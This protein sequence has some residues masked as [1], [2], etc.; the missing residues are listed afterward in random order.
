MKLASLKSHRDGTLIVVDSKLQRYVVAEGI[1]VTLQSALDRWDE[2]QPQ[3]LELAEH[4]EQG[5]LQ[6]QLFDPSLCASPLPRAYQWADGSAYV[7]H[8]ELVRKARNAEMPESFWKDPLMYQGGSDSF[9]SPTE[10]ICLAEESWGIDFEAEVAVITD[11]VPMGIDPE[12]AKEHIQLIMLVNDISLRN[13][14]ADELKKGFGFFQSK[15]S[16]AFSPVA[17]TPHSLGSAWEDGKLHLPV[18]ATLNGKL[19]GQPNAGID[20]TFDFGQLIAHAAKTRSLCAGTIIGS[21][22]VSNVDK[23]QGSCCLAEIR[24]IETIIDGEAK[25]PFMRHGDR[26]QIEAYNA[27][28]ES[29]FGQIDQYLTK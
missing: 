13:V 9:L 26:I 18:R 1:A 8:M 19:V 15:P 29:V 21:G 7:N 20:M 10:D 16:S 17:V 5:S 27:L 14:I 24:M 12:A 28:G 22:T 6:G 4:L 23:S 25:T 2:C 3:L 11:D